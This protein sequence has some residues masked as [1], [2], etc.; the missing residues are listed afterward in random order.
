MALVLCA[1]TDPLLVKTR[2]LMLEG[3]G[4][5]VI[6]ATDE[7]TIL[8]ACQ[9]HTFDVAVIG[10]RIPPKLKKQMRFLI[11]EHSPATRILEMYLASSG[12]ILEDADAWLEASVPTPQDFTGYVAALARNR[13]SDQGKR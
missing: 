8:N 12:R 2:Q 1:G 7:I 3:A 6:A 5:T 11:R 9:Q 13:R 10:Q 4:H